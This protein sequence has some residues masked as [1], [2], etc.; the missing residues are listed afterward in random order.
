[1][2]RNQRDETDEVQNILEFK[3]TN[4]NTPTITL[5]GGLFA[6]GGDLYWKG[7]AGTQSRIAVS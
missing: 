4:D 6:S 2:V 5:S 7:Y 1:M 3:E